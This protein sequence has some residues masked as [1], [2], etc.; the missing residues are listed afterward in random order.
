MGLGGPPKCMKTQWLGDGAWGWD[1]RFRLSASEAR[2]VPLRGATARTGES[3][4]PQCCG[5]AFD[6][7]APAL[8][9]TL[10]A[11]GRFFASRLLPWYIGNKETACGRTGNT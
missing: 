2:P 4:V 8:V 9:P 1:R 3:P 11:H 6:A 7:A 10:G 5:R